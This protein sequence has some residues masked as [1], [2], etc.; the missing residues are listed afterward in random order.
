[1]NTNVHFH[2]LV[3][4]GVF[5]GLDAGTPGA[6]RPPPPVGY[7]RPQHYAWADLLQRTFSFDVLACPDCGGRL[8]R[9]ATIDDPAVI[10]KI[11]RHLQLPVD[12][13]AAAPA[14]VMGWLPGIVSIS[15]PFIE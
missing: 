8:R 14:R 12:R 4:Q 2:T 10:E 6:A 13:P 5:A 9:L 3:A 7:A 11:L 15:E 1:L